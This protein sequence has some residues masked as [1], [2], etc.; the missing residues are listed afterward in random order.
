VHVVA[1]RVREEEPA[2]TTEAARPA[3]PHGAHT[4]Q[5]AVGNR[6]VRRALQRSVPG[7]GRIDPAEVEAERNAAAVLGAG[8]MA[9]RRCACGGLVLG[10]G[11]CARCRAERLQRRAATGSVVEAGEVT[12]TPAV[13]RVLEQAGR[14]LDPG[15]RASMEERLGSDFGA[16]RV[17][18]GHEAGAAARSV[19]ADAFTVG[20]DV[21][22]GEGKFA[23]DV[24]EGRALIAHELTH[25]AQQAEGTPRLARQPRSH[26]DETKP[27]FET[28]VRDRAAT[29]LTQNIGVLGEWSAYINTMEGFQLRAQLLT[30]TLMEHAIVAGGSAR[31]RQR[32]EAEV[33][34]ENAAERAYEGSVLDIES[35]YRERSNNFM[36]LLA[37]KTQGYWTTPT[38]AQRMQVLAGDRPSEDLPESRWVGADPRYH[39]YAAPIQRFQRH[40]MGGCETCHEINWAWQRTIEEFGT[41]LP[42]DDLLKDF[43]GPLSR[44]AMPSFG[45]P[46]SGDQLR[47]LSAWVQAQSGSAPS[48]LLPTTAAPST[49]L[50][51]TAAPSTLLPTAPVSTPAPAGANPFIPSGPLPVGLE[52]PQPRTNLCGDLPEAEDSPRVPRFEEWGPNSAIVADVIGRI[53]SVLLPL[54]PR[55]YRVLGRQI[56]DQLWAVS[57]DNMQS[58]RDGIIARIA[59]KQQQYASLRA[60]IQAGDVPYEELCPIVDELLPT[61][62]DLVR[63]FVLQDVSAWQT[64][65]RVLQILELVL[66]ALSILYPPSMVLTIPAGMALGLARASLG[67]SQ[68]RQG[69][70]WTQ[71]MGAGIYSHQQEAEAPTLESR[72]RTNIITGTLSFGLSAVSFVRMVSEARATAQLLEALEAGAVI[73][74]AQYPG[75]ALLA[76]NGRLL[77]V[78]DTGEVL[79]YGMIANGRIFWARL[80]VPFNPFTSAPGPA[81]AGAGAGSSIVPFGQTAIVPYGPTS[82]VPFGPSSIVPYGPSAI[83]PLAPSAIVPFGPS[84][85][86]PYGPTSIVPYGPTSIVPYG[87]TSI[88]PYG[89]TSIV[90]Y[91]PT[92]IVPYGPTSI[93]PYG[94]TSFGGSTALLSAGTPSGPVSTLD[95]GGRGVYAMSEARIS[96]LPPADAARL[97]LLQSRLPT[98]PGELAELVDLRSRAANASLAPIPGTPEHMLARW[99]QYSAPPRSGLM[100]FQ[101]W[102]AGHPSRMANSVTGPATEE[103]YRSALAEANVVARSAVL[104]TPSGQSRQ[105]DALIEGGRGQGRNLIQIKAG[106]EALT[107]TP[108]QSGGSSLGSASLSNEAA[109]AA[110]AEFVAMGDRVTWVFE[111]RPSGPLV[112]RAR[113]SGIDVIIRVNDAAGRARMITLMQ[114]AGMTQA[115]IN[116]VTFV[117]GTIDDVVAFAARRFGAR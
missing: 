83:V 79:G 37:S 45:T 18:S 78:T 38:I 75:L 77:L 61:T 12:S 80:E 19:D 104:R 63:Y 112:A 34:T 114:R 32:F 3:R 10:S 88:V 72:G 111:Q 95:P 43:H 44:A 8:R 30:G 101:R 85:I 46:L 48:T 35:T 68:E 98:S 50:P 92:S 2:R 86:V 115:E 21:V 76:R 27:Q 57:P 41:P 52:L 49:L 16:V 65:E 53:D 87:P 105:V 69:R 31:G 107:T 36:G 5:R 39:W 89:P 6:A 66:L 40:E 7:R 58:V 109:L 24:A 64:R 29:R 26:E 74:H 71:G 106:E 96:T 33:G 54:G 102:A 116:N 94:S 90:P 99:T 103:R 81:G 82:I 73:R 22:F 1:E 59:E 9:P 42:N 15:V 28:R 100:T 113:E 84:A 11:E 4:L 23:P 51:T 110:D 91:G 67:I 70:Q 20:S 25:V 14:P 60:D 13:D 93:V 47:A 17:H 55:G 108:R 56:F 62:N 117:E 97:R